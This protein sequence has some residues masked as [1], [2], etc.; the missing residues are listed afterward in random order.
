LDYYWLVID[1]SNL[2]INKATLELIKSL[3][4]KTQAPDGNNRLT[5]DV[6][7]KEVLLLNN[8]FFK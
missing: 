4:D 1:N 5:S 6:S 8:K 3:I 7:D 2:S